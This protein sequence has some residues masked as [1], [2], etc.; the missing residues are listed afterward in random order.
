MKTIK[1]LRESNF[2]SF[3]EEINSLLKKGYKLPKNP[4][5]D[6]E[7]SLIHI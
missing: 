4:F 7:L 6:N 3:E 5:V 2:K 1:M